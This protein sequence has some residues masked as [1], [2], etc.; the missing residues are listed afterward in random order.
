MNRFA[1]FALAMLFPF[2]AQAVSADSFNKFFVTQWGPTP[3][4]AS[5]HP[6]GYADCGPSALLMGAAALGIV[7]PPTA[8]SSLAEIRH[9]RALIRGEATTVS[10]ATYSPMMIR[11]AEALLLKPRRIMTN[12][13]G[14]RSAIQNG[15]IALISGDPRTSWGLELDSAHRYLHHYGAGGPIP[16]PDKPTSN[17][18]HFGHWVIVFGMSSK[19]GFYIGDPL[20]IGGVIE[21]SSEA[22]DQFFAEWP[23]MTDALAIS[24]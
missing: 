19:K 10:S 14:V 7:D 4:N 5:G 13:S 20:S 23:F 9:M 18:D 2:V 8:N 17:V 1:L 12:S 16:H 3:F 24:R 11:G 21:V 15:E 22:I 6:D